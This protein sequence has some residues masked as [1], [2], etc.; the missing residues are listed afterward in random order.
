MDLITVLTL[1][2]CVLLA[3][4]FVVIVR[5]LAEEIAEDIS[6]IKRRNHWRKRYKHRKGK[7]K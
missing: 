3:V 2:V 1:L 4:C 5:L 7:R 6:S